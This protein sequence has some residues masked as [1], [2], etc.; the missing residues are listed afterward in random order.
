MLLLLRMFVRHGVPVFQESGLRWCWCGGFDSLFSPHVCTAAAAAAHSWP[1]AVAFC[2][3]LAQHCNGHKGSA[4]SHSCC[5]KPKGVQTYVYILET[6]TSNTGCITTSPLFWGMFLIDILFFLFV[7][8]FVR[9]YLLLSCEGD[10][11]CVAHTI[12]S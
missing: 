2:M 7:L 9:I 3:R 6:Q 4:G 8:L 1:L 12:R 11:P 5:T 10:L